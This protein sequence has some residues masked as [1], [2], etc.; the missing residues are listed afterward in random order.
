MGL[1]LLRIP[2]LLLFLTCLSTCPVPALFAQNTPDEGE[3][4]PELKLS[5]PQKM[6]QREYLNVDRDPFSLSEI[7]CE[8]LI[9]EVF[10]L[11]CP[12]CQKEAPNVNGL[13]EVISANPEI[14]Q[15][16]KVLGIGAGNSLFE[17]NAFRD[18]YRIEFPL[19]PDSDFTV[20]KMLGQVRT[21]YFLVLSKV[22]TGWLVVYSRVGGIGD[23]RTF[24]DQ[25]CAKISNARG[26]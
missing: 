26:K 17:V 13:Y 3:M 21:P 22:P 6:E 1:K 20:H 14:K 15:R 25:I 19:I 4:F 9:I 18:L 5:I 10:S 24:L 12:Y 8:V 2:V 16:V 23:P 11:Y 7:D